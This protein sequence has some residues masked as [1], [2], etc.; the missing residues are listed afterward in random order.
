MTS[1]ET[2]QQ[3]RLRLVETYGY[4]G[5]ALLT[6][7]DGWRYF[8]PSGVDG[9]IAY[10]VHRKTAVACGDPVCD[11]A[12]L[13]ELMSRF[14]TYCSG[15]GW[16]FSFV[17]AGERVAEAAA[18]LGLRA[19]KVGE[20]PF[21]DLS[22]Y[23][24]SGKGA[25]KARSAINLARRTGVT[26]HEYAQHSPAIDQEV[27]DITEEWLASRDA[28][29]MGFLLRSRPFA[30]RDRKRTFLA[31]HEGRMVG[32][33]TC[34][35]APARGLLYVEEQVRRVDAPYGTSELLI[36]EARRM[37][38]ASGF[39][40]LSLGTAP[41]QGAGDQPYGRYRALRLLF[42]AMTSRANF[43]Y[44]FR[45]LNHFKRKFAPTFWENSYFIYGGSVLFPVIATMSAFAPDGLPSLLLPKR[46]QWLRSVP[47]AALWAAAVA[48]VVLTGVSA[49]EF[50][51]LT[52]PLR[53]GLEATVFAFIPADLVI[54]RAEGVALSHRILTLFA[55]LV[56]GAFAWQRRA[57]A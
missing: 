35:I 17:G 43:V 20:E 12:A 48:G 18:A 14:A 40:L 8:E 24:L 28:L 52:L 19:V 1:S 9:F 39:R 37:A 11:P 49:Y 13:G 51:A 38:A 6:L 44:S 53:A 10:E 4:N 26:V 21:F 45:S 2:S 41:L 22:T 27:M 32:A 29:P 36:E 54:D 42:K 25:K 7:Y 56:G 3:R 50:P 57:R 34:A 23:S 33:M 47:A 55:V 31:W 5:L 16:R 46:M 15:R 30:L